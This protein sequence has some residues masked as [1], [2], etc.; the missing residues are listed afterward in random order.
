VKRIGVLYPG[1]LGAAFGHAIVK[2]G[3]TAITCLAGRSAATV[4][5]A[6]AASFMIMPSLEE[7]ARLSDIVISAVPASSAIEVARSF[8]ECLANCGARRGEPLIFVDANSV[9]PRSKLRIG[10]LLRKEGVPYVDGAFF[11]PANRIGHDTVFALSGSA[12]IDIAPMLGQ[13]MEVRVLGTEEGQASALKMAMA[14]MTKGIPALFVEAVCAAMNSGQ[15]D[16]TLEMLGHLYPGILSFLER[17]LPTYPTH[18][19]RRLHELEEAA[20][21]L[22]DFGQCGVMTQGAI[23]VLERFRR[24]DVEGTAPTSLKDVLRRIGQADVLHV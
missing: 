15:L 10:D 24:A 17:T 13:A 22:Q 11:G 18:I 9:A 7:V 1:E 5:R 14:I 8:A 23:S 4:S 20:E 2:A 16:S 19:A 12:A 21:W 6:A 3:G